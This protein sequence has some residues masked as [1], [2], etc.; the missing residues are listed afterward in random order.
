MEEEQSTTINTQKIGLAGA[1][2]AYRLPFLSRYSY[3]I[4]Y[5]R[6]I[7]KTRGARAD[8]QNKLNARYDIDQWVSSSMT[9]L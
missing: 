9:C 8:G 3:F 6:F 5:V 1:L 2:L 4:Y 7:N